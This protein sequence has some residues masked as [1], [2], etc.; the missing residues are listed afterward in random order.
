MEHGE[1][2]TR[3]STSSSWNLLTICLVIS[4]V[5]Y[6]LHPPTALSFTYSSTYTRSDEPCH[7]SG[8]QRRSVNHQVQTR[9]ASSVKTKLFE[10]TKTHRA[11]RANNGKSTKGSKGGRVSL[12]CL[13]KIHRIFS[14]TFVFFIYSRVVGVYL[15]NHLNDNGAVNNKIIINVMRRKEW[16]S[17]RKIGF[18]TKEHMVNNRTKEASIF[19][20]R[21][22]VGGSFSNDQSRAMSSISLCLC[23]FPLRVCQCCPACVYYSEKKKGPFIARN[24]FA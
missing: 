24:G 11:V 3:N 22:S 18:E 8:D 16:N 10:H 1:D 19:G 4:F 23:N 13:V 21:G 6:L 12:F 5:C 9:C 2:E 14:L 7:T 15:A 17:R 20:L